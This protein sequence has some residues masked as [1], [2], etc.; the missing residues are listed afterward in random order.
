VRIMKSKKRLEH[1]Q[2]I[3]EVLNDMSVAHAR[4]V[5]RR[6]E[7]LIEREYLKRDEV[8]HSVYHYVA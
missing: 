4:M 8:D 7:H 6:I 2:L 5:R 3:G 1:N